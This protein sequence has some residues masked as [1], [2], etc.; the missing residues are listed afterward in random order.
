MTEAWP[1]FPIFLKLAGEPVLVVGGGEV[2][3]RKVRLLR[4]AGARVRLVAR[5]LHP[6]LAT[7]GLAPVAAQFEAS[8]LDGC[9]L[10]IAATDDAAL[11]AGVARAARERGIPVNVVDDE[12]AGTWVSGAIVDRAPVLVAI[13]S[14]GG[15]PVLAR[16]LRERLEAL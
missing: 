7:L 2:A 3:L 5:E 6:E 14:G 9:R 10:A 8:L 15:A 13:S 12:A 1:Y 16:R 11:N 4:R